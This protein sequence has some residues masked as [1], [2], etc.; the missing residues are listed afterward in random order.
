MKNETFEEAHLMASSTTSAD[1]YIT[2]LDET[3]DI[4]VVGFGFAGAVAAIKAHNQD[5]HVLLIEKMPDPGDISICSDL[6]DSSC[7]G[8]LTKRR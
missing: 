8:S 7:S 2:R 5:A 4:V 1:R 6:A 3:F